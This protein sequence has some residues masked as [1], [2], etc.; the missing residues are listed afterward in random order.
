MD[1]AKSKPSRPDDNLF[2]SVVEALIVVDVVAMIVA[3]A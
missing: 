3:V 1:S 2:W